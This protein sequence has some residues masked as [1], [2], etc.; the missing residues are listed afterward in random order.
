MVAI[1]E[2]SFVAAFLRMTAKG[3]GKGEIEAEPDRWESVVR[4][5]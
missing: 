5:L 4:I 3:G 1:E 2:R